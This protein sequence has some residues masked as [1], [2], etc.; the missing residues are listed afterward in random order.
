MFYDPGA[1]T[2]GYYDLAHS[3]HAKKLTIKPTLR[4]HDSICRLLSPFSFQHIILVNKSTIPRLNQSSSFHLS[5]IT[6]LLNNSTIP[7]LNRSSNF[8]LPILSPFSYNSL[9]K[10]FNDS[11]IKPVFQH[12]ATNP[13]T[14]QL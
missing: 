5:A 9:V 6:V 8:Q 4:L 11:T 1:G 12:P 7:R 3:G 10:Q 14:F 2:P 13:F